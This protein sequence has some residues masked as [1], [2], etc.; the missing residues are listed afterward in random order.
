MSDPQR[1]PLL[2]LHAQHAQVRDE[3]E[4]AVRAVFDSQ[5]FILGPVVEEFEASVAS[6]SQCKHGV[7]MSS[8]TDA[9][10]AALMAEGIGAGDEV[11]TSA[12][13]FFATAGVVQR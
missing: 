4:A 5:R 3:V 6:Y 12:F 8:G 10:L 2:D 13:S 11:I 1:V 9:L 7:G